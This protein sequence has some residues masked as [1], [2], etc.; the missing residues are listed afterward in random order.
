MMDDS[1]IAIGTRIEANGAPSFCGLETT[2]EVQKKDGSAC[3]NNF[4]CLSNTCNTGLCVNLQAEIKETRNVVQ[5]LL[6]WL[7]TLFGRR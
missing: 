4:E 7:G 6:D 5:Q 1:C 2:L 3:Q